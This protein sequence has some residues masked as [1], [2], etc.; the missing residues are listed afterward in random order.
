MPPSELWAMCMTHRSDLYFFMKQKGIGV[1]EMS[2]N[3]L[4]NT[5]AYATLKAL[6]QDN[7]M[8]LLIELPSLHQGR[9]MD[10]LEA[11]FN[12]YKR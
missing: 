2:R 4:K 5:E 12:Q 3:K 9:S 8:N 1:T 6:L 11:S 10:N 7:Q